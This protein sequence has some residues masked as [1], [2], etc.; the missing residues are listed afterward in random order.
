M[1]NKKL[2]DWVVQNQR[3][4]WKTVKN[5]RAFYVIKKKLLFS[6]VCIKSFK[7]AKKDTKNVKL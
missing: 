5:Y 2:R 3:L 6:C 1:K 4:K 7:S